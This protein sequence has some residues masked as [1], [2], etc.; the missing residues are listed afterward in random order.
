MSFEQASSVIADENA[1]VCGYC[2]RPFVRET[3]LS[4]HRGLDH[5]DALTDDERAAF[6]AA[7]AAE[8]EAIRLFRLKAILA[9]VVVYF[10]FLIVFALVT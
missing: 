3:Q 4:L 10:G 7:H 9:L 8:S 2:G 5:P 6:E 1:A